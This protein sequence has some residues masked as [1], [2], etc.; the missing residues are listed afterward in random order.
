LAEIQ[1][2][3]RGLKILE[4]LAATDKVS[5]TEV[6]DQLNVDK[7][8]ASRL[9]QTLANYGYAEKDLDTQ[10]YRLGPKIVE[11]SQS[12]LARM[13]FRDE[14]KPYLRELVAITNECAHLAIAAQG[15]VLYID[16]VD[17][18]ATLRV[19]A[20]IGHLAPLHCTALGKVLLAFGNVPLPT[21]LAAHTPRTITNS[22]A[23][24][25]HLAQVKR[26]GY[27]IDDEEYDYGV[28]CIAAPVYNLNGEM[29][30]AMGISG[31]SNRMSL[32]IISTMAAKVT[33]VA[34]AL[35][36]HLSFKRP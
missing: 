29:V 36:D 24:Q 21:E 33:G 20:D 13:P 17:S 1:S 25:M 32:E 16:Q 3:A 4:L 35:S 19:N 12:L 18:P 34:Q 9:M 26:Q 30:A 6:A 8:S 14:A 10:R 27:A 28:R 23:L 22:E 2:L 7:A 5:I 15:Q 11:L 31:P